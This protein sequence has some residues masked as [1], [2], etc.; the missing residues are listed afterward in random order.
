[1]LDGI[2]NLGDGDSRAGGRTEETAFENGRR[3]RHSRLTTA[4]APLLCLRSIR[5][6]SSRPLFYSAP[7]VPIWVVVVTAVGAT[8]VFAPLSAHPR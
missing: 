7:I 5:P 8:T 4:T 6:L 1:M 2:W 3:G